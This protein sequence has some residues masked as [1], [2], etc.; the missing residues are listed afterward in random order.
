MLHGIQIISKKIRQ[1]I[2]CEYHLKTHRY[3]L[4]Q[5]TLVQLLIYG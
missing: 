5:L 2:F 4:H 1:L 3:L